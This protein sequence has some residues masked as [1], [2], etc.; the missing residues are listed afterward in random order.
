MLSAAAG[1]EVI[2]SFIP[3]LSFLYNE[4]KLG[5]KKGSA[6]QISII[7]IKRV[8]R[9]KMNTL[10]RKEYLKE[11]RLRSRRSYIDSDGGVCE[12]RVVRTPW[13]SWGLLRSPGLLRC[14]TNL[15]KF[16]SD[17]SSFSN[18]MIHTLGSSPCLFRVGLH[19]LHIGSWWNLCIPPG[20]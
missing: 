20:R 1:V 9:I 16:W 7:I 2:I 15:A 6:W 14:F 17:D 13:Q 10:K 4:I 18:I 5:R 11:K 3:I 19:M 8:K 12:V